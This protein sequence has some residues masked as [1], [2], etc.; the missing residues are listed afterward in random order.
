[1]NKNKKYSDIIIDIFEKTNDTS[2]FRK[3]VN[4]YLKISFNKILGSIIEETR[5]EHFKNNLTRKT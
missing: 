3:I 4:K 2:E 1:M 5:N